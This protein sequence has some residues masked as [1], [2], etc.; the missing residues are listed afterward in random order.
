[1]QRKRKFKGQIILLYCSFYG[2]VRMIIEGLRTDSLYLGNYRISQIVSIILI[3]V[4]IIGNELKI[5]LH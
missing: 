5:Q 4:G 3:I 2:F 1:M